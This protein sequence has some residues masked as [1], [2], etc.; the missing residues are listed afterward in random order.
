MSSVSMHMQILIEIHSFIRKIL[1]G[2]EIVTSFKGHNSAMNWQKSHARC[3]H[4]D[5]TISVHMQN[6]VKIHQN[7]PKILS[8]NENVMDGRTDG[9][10]ENSI[11][12]HTS[13]A[14][15]DIIKWSKTKHVLFFKNIREIKP[16]NCQSLNTMILTFISSLTAFLSLV[17]ICTTL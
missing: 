11:P 15:G 1:S 10:P 3:R 8:G 16:T 6:L 13:Y 12:P 7:F 5:I 14:G 2:N 4:V 9:Q 17:T